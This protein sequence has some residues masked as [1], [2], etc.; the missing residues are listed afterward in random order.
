VG[1]IGSTRWGEH[2]RKTTVEEC[3]ALRVSSFRGFEHRVGWLCWRSGTRSLY[4]MGPDDRSVFLAL[5]ST[6]GTRPDVLIVPLTVSYPHFGGTRWWFRCP[7]CRRRVAVLYRPPRVKQLAC[8][9]CHDLTYESAQ[10]RRTRSGAT[11]SAWK[12]VGLL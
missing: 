2:D 11:I 12:A 9:H 3:Q 6:T 5:P 8:R 10:L 4:R 1:G 7:V